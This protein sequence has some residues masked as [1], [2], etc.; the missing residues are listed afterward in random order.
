M[1]LQS[2]LKKALQIAGLSLLITS[3]SAEPIPVELRKTESGWQLLRGG[4]PYLVK[5]AGG[6]HSLQQLADAGA[7][8]LLLGQTA[9]GGARRVG[10]GALRITEIRGDRQPAPVARSKR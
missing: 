9:V 3:A 6:T 8:P 5:G 10:D 4:E 2:V 1:P 7:I